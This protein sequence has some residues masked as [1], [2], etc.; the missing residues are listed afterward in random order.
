MSYTERKAIISE[1][2]RERQSKVITLITSDRYSTLSL[3]G[4]QGLIASDQIYKILQHVKELSKTGEPEKIDL[5]IYSRGGDVNSAWPIV[6]SI[7]S[8]CK[9][10]T[11]LIPLHAHS[12]ATLICLGADSVVMSKSASLSPIDPTVANAFNPKDASSNQPLGISVEDVA[13][14][15]SLAMDKNRVGIKSESSMTEV[16]KLLAQQVHPLALGNVKR[17]HSQIRHLASKLLNLHITE[18]AASKKIDSI[19]DELTER[20]YTHNHSIFR[21]EAKKIGLDIMIVDANPKEEAL[22]WELY[23]NYEKDMQLKVFFDPSSFLGADSEKLLETTPV[24]IESG[25]FSSSFVFKQK[26]KK[27]VVPDPNFRLQVIS[28]N[29]QNR[30]T[31]RNLRTQLIQLQANFAQFSAQILQMLQQS[32]QNAN[33]QNL[34]NSCVTIDRNINSLLTSIPDSINI[35]DLKRQFEFETQSIEWVDKR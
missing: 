18:D 20:F 4:I 3:P 30:N 13:S 9:S 27:A 5:F 32:P 14:F 24:F 35:E 6:N 28:L 2:E 1:I 22:L 15:F 33:L 21:G 23:E 11:V 10:F 12:A 8:Y 25:C 16:F 7:R 29:E 26:I 17:S 19:V 31:F 34:N